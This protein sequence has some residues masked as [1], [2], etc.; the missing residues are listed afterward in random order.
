MKVLSPLETIQEGVAVGNT[1]YASS[2]LNTPRRNTPLAS[3]YLGHG[4]NQNFMSGVLTPA[5]I[6]SRTSL[7]SCEKDAEEGGLPGTGHSIIGRA[8][9][10]LG[11]WLTDHSSR[12]D[13]NRSIHSAF[14]GIVSRQTSVNDELEHNSDPLAIFSKDGQ[15]VDC[16]VGS[17]SSSN[18][19]KLSPVAEFCSSKLQIDNGGVLIELNEHVTI[20]LESEEIPC[21]TRQSNE[22]MHNSDTDVSLISTGEPCPDE[23]VRLDLELGGNLDL[24][25]GTAI[26]TEPDVFGLEHTPQGSEEHKDEPPAN[27]TDK[28]GLKSRMIVTQVP[29]GSLTW[30]HS[31]V[32]S[33]A[34]W[35][36]TG[37]SNLKLSLP[38]IRLGDGRLG[39]GELPPSLAQTPAEAM[40]TSFQEFPSH[41]W[42]PQGTATSNLEHLS[43]GLSAQLRDRDRH[44]SDSSDEYEMPESNQCSVTSMT[45][46]LT[47]DMSKSYLLEFNA[48]TVDK[49]A[50]SSQVQV[51]SAL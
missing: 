15:T 18:G 50:V 25:L 36:E 51:T 16:R 42:M 6:R 9:E 45:P 40:P 46:L 47:S 27:I 43:V 1:A 11:K 37:P 38:Q 21:A 4:H 28:P 23:S 34:E 3:P 19:A 33:T 8:T 20:E 49:P 35:Q 14:V 29:E 12:T 32:L 31:T 48:S 30:D 24:D 2:Y 10:K 44:C 7:H 41:G 22:V 39:N 5:E 13:L 26:P 17:L